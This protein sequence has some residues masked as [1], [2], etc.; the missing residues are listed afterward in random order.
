MTIMLKQVKKAVHFLVYTT[1]I[2]WKVKKGKG[3]ILQKNM[4]ISHDIKF[5]LQ[6]LITKMYK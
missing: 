4:T 3:F 1:K 6:K 5:S 2:R